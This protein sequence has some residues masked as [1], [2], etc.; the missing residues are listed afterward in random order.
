MLM[1]KG[2]LKVLLITVMIL[3][4]AFPRIG[5]AYPGAEEAVVRAVERVEPSVVFLSIVWANGHKNMGSGVI[6][7]SD[8][9][10]VTNAHVTRNAH[11]IF[12]TTS[13]G[14]TH[15]ASDWR[16]RPVD[17]IAVVKID[18]VNLPTAPLGDSDRL[19]KGQI[20][21]AIGNPWQFTSTVTVGC[22]SAVERKLQAVISRQQINLEGLIQTDAAINPGNSG[23][24]LVNS[25]GQ[26]IGINTLVYT[27]S[28][29]DFAQGLSFAIPINRAMEL[30]RGLINQDS[31]G[32]KPW[33]GLSVAQITPEMNYPVKWGAVIMVFPPNSPAQR[34]G[35]QVGDIILYLN[36]VPI[37]EVEDFSRALSGVSPGD[38]V[39]AVVMRAGKKYQATITV[40]GMRQ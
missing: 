38:K 9:W 36:D 29:G 15:P 11:K 31:S 28:R 16:A 10:I 25:S 1:K 39:T 3:S 27:G 20:A 14:K 7:T 5:L 19:R 17:D 33:M 21:V 23:G 13:D 26:V 40:E 32:I 8:G 6:I 37:R 34:A 30:A 12:V 22:I 18:G 35:L 24:A 4:G 2:V